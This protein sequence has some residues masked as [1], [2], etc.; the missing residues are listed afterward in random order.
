MRPLEYGRS[1]GTTATYRHDGDRYRAR[2]TA[3]TLGERHA[4]RREGLRLQ[5]ERPTAAGLMYSDTGGDG[6]VISLPGS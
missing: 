2:N 1:S 3:A 4:N 5:L 6:P